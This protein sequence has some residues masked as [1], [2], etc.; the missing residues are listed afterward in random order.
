[1]LTLVL[2]HGQISFSTSSVG[3]VPGLLGLL[4]K[5]SRQDSCISYLGYSFFLVH[6]PF[7]KR[8]LILLSFV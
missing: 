1:M 6:F 7:F 3:K 5:V 2:P 4:A 8:F